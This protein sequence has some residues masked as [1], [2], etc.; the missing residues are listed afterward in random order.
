MKHFYVNGGDLYSSDTPML[1]ENLVEIT[2]E[3]YNNRRMKLEEN[4]EVGIPID[5]T[6]NWESE[7]IA[8]DS[9]YISA[10]ESLGVGFGG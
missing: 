9:D 6:D 2:E 4:R 5:V 1:G 10:L 8:T 7:D 3:E